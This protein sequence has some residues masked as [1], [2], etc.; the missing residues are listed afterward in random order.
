MITET[1]Y[2]VHHAKQNGKVCI[3]D[4][5][6][7]LLRAAD[8]LSRYLDQ[9]ETGFDREEAAEFGFKISEANQCKQQARVVGYALGYVS[10]NIISNLRI[11]LLADAQARLQVAAEKVL[12]SNT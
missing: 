12:S 5:R 6:D 7:A 11:D 4:A 2:L 9:Y 3:E 1:D 10:T 8:D